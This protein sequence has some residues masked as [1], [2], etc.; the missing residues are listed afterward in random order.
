MA[1]GKVF[2][3]TGWLLSAPGEDIPGLVRAVYGIKQIE[4]RDEYYGLYKFA[5]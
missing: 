1:T 3:D 2:D 5:D 4:L